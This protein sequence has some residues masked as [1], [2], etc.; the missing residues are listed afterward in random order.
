MYLTHDDGVAL[1][2]RV[3]EHFPS[4]ELQF[5]VYNWLGIKSQKNKPR[6]SPL[7]VDAVLGGQRAG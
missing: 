2:R 3:V 6:G 7:W 4:G 5:D 1:L